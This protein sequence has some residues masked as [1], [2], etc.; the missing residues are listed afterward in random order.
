G[1]M[2]T[3]QEALRLLN[4][5]WRLSVDGLA[6][7]VIAGVS[8]NPDRHDFMVLSNAL[9]CAARVVKPQGRIILLT[10]AEPALGVATEYLRQAEDPGRALGLIRRHA[11]LGM[12]AAFQWASAAQCAKIYLL[13]RLPA[14]TA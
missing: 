8:G 3:G 12:A 14:E 10:Q 5:R 7:L 11:P 4:A 9:A 2:D 1:L 13:S 6:D